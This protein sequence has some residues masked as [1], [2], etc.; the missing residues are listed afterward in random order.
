MADEKEILIT[1][2]L[3][4][5]NQN[6]R[7]EKALETQNK[8]L[9]KIIKQAPLEGEKGYEALSKEIDKANKLYSENLATLK[10]VR[11]E[12][13]TGN[14]EVKAATDSLKGM[15]KQLKEIDTQYRLLTKAERKTP[16]GR[17]LKKEVKNLRG[18]LKRAEKGIGD[19][20]RG[21][22]DYTRVLGVLGGSM[23]GIAVS[24]Q[25]LSGVFR[26]LNGSLKGASKGFKALLLTLGPI[27]AIIG[28]IAAAM[29][30]F[31]SVIDA[32]S[33][34]LAG[35]SAAFDVISERVGR[36]GAAFEK[37]YDLDFSGFAESFKQ[38][39][40]GIGD[41]IA[42]E[43][44]LAIKLK[45]DYNKL[46]DDE[47]AAIVPL[48]QLNLEIAEARKKA[49]ELE[50]TNQKEAL[51]QLDEA[52]LKTK[53]R[54]DIEL[55]LAQRRTKILRD[56]I[57]QTDELTTRQD[58]EELQNQI[59]SE[60]ILRKRVADEIRGLQRVRQKFIKVEKDETSQL[61]K[62]LARQT[63]LSKVI[64]EQILLGQDTTKSAEEQ[65][66]IIQRL[67]EVEE[68][69]KNVLGET[70]EVVQFQKN[71]VND[72][73]DQLQK[74]QA[75]LANTTVGSKAYLDTEQKIARV[76]AKRNAA[77]GELNESLKRLTET[78]SNAIQDLEGLETEL[79]LREE[80][81]ML[82]KQTTDA[83]QEGAAERME[84]EKQT[85]K[86][87]EQAQQQRLKDEL[88]ALKEQKADI[89]S[90]LQEELALYADNEDKKTELY[91]QAQ[92]ARDEITRREF[93]LRKRLI[94]AETEN[95]KEELSEQTQKALRSEEGKR[96]AR[97]RTL[98]FV[99]NAGSAAASILN[100]FVEKETAAYLEGINTREEAALKEADRVGKTEE[101]K[102][103]I[104]EQFEEERIALEKRAA[105]ERKAIA[106][107]E[108]A[109]DIAAAVI[110]VLPTPALVPYVLG[111]GALQVATIAAA[112]FAEGGKVNS[113]NEKLIQP[114]QTMA[115]ATGGI[116][117]STVPVQLHGGK[118]TMVPNIP[119]LSNGDNILATVAKGETILNPPQVEALGGSSV[120]AAI[121]VPG[122][123]RGG[124]IQHTG[125]KTFESFHNKYTPRFTSSA[126]RAHA[127]NTGGIAVA[128][129]IRQ[130][131][132]NEETLF[133]DEYFERMGVIFRE[134]IKEGIEESDLS[135]QIN[136]NNERQ[137]QQQQRQTLG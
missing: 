8:R 14:K 131:S 12:R 52:I 71:S 48:A 9:A 126:I 16:F 7:T 122:Y 20:R 36:L 42:N 112:Q 41:E 69:Y 10:K 135:N 34:K 27:A 102:Q 64:K 79:R 89:D 18:E 50:K 76:T 5:S 88:E 66:A 105:N 40:T 53:E 37:L 109:V 114:L 101:E 47:I 31:Q 95:V 38:A 119:A 110:K 92:L 61:D 1:L 137:Q 132:S 46:L 107:A 113:Q 85:N 103:E 87:I 128:N 25:T 59:K 44:K 93:D 134:N 123:A 108:A 91:L 26:G 84:I 51:A 120:M 77:T 70:A 3:E 127:Y 82:L 24:V 115:F 54:G 28:V 11:K 124:K 65:R 2:K 83:T 72:Y 74:L 4:Q 68:E 35:V 129:Q 99:S 62:L 22:G 98:D 118:I 6:K 30:R 17:K 111:L 15:S 29:S 81:L 125:F 33:E 60:L 67:K 43:F 104:R 100:S 39:F 49:Q 13:R 55:D 57:N 133:N 73:N 75:T 117:N 58:R 56:Q 63:E 106:L 23:G 19:F 96:S 130:L 80:N 121:G 97:E 45:E 86:D 21:V 94:E 116:A 78:Q 32:F 136:R 90:S